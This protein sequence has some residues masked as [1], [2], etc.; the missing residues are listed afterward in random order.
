M[1]LKVWLNAKGGAN[2]ARSTKGDASIVKR[3]KGSVDECYSACKPPFY[4]VWNP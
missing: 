4:N 1:I 2:M 3:I